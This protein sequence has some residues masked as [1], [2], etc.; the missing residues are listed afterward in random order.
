MPFCRSCGKSVEVL[1]RFCRECGVAQIP[2]TGTSSEDRIDQA[3]PS[4]ES[5]V[6]SSPPIRL[7]AGIQADPSCQRCRKSIPLS[8]AVCPHCGE[9]QFTRNSKAS[10]PPSEPI[11]HAI[12]T[13]HED[14]TDATSVSSDQ[15]SYGS[16]RVAEGAG[17]GAGSSPGTS[18][19]SRVIRWIVSLAV[20]GGIVVGI[21]WYQE[22]NARD[23]VA[24]QNSAANDGVGS[25]ASLNSGD[26]NVFDLRAG[27][28]ISTSVTGTGEYETV[29]VVPCSSFSATARILESFTVARSGTFPGDEFF[30]REGSR[31]C[32][33]QA[34]GSFYPTEGS[35]ELGDRTI[36]CYEDID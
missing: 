18:A 36:S 7:G 29:N 25:A 5:H 32:P 26:T 6:A 34:S 8:S 2:T 17:V 24:A 31:R 15:W 10:F 30:D 4:E 16:Y 23:Q 27:D 22:R 12:D 13:N 14:K 28:C 11:T 1:D 19:T 21:A 33:A 20:L 3:E 9:V 35:W